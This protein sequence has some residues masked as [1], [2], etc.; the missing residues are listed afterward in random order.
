MYLTLV[1][2]CPTDTVLEEWS[3]TTC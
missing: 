2:K 3:V 1:K